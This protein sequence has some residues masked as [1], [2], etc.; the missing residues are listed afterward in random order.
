MR[1][2]SPTTTFGARCAVAATVAES[3]GI[4][5]ASASCTAG[6]PSRLPSR[7]AVAL[8]LP[9]AGLALIAVGG[10]WLCLWRRSWRFAGLIGLAAGLTSLWLQPFPDILVSEDGR[11][12]AVRMEDGKLSLS[13]GRAERRPARRQQRPP[14][15]HGWKTAPRDLPRSWTAAANK[16]Y[17]AA[18]R[19]RPPASE[20]CRSEPRRARAAADPG[21]QPAARR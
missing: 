14:P 3:S 1:E 21:M 18:C 9:V 13:T 17:P 10:L 15:A 5:A 6:W 2:R 19:S 16:P 11:L 7:L 12:M 8:A 4:A 20:P